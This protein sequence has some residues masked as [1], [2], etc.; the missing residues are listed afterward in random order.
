MLFFKRANV[1]RLS[2]ESGDNDKER[3]SA[4]AQLFNIE[5][6]IQPATAELT[7]VAEGVYGQTFRAFVS[8]SGIAVGDQV[9]VSGTGDKY[10]VKGVQD[11]HY[12]PLP[13]FELVLFKG[14]N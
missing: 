2:P 14:D 1:A 4:V 8:V 5:I 10:I 11:W 3:Y 9:T 7:A 6:D 13:H 12:G